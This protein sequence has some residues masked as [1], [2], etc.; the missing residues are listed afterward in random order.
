MTLR[1]IGVVLITC[2][3]SIILAQNSFDIEKVNFEDLTD[4]NIRLYFEQAKRSGYSENQLI[5]IA[6]LKGLNEIQISN[7]KSRIGSLSAQNRDGTPPNSEGRLR[8]VLNSPNIINPDLKT[9]FQDGDGNKSNEIFGLSFFRNSKLTFQ[10]SLNSPTPE[11]YIVG[12]GDEIIIDIWGAAEQ[13]YNLTV[14]PEGSIRIPDIGPVYLNGY[15]VSQVKKRIKSSL[16]KIYSSLDESTYADVS[17]GKIRSVRFHVIGEALNPGTYSISSFGNV[18][19]ALQLAGGPNE[20]GSLRNIQIFRRN[21]LI[22][23]LDIYS[24][25]SNGVLPVTQ[26]Q[27]QDI[28]LIPFYKKRV[29]LTGEVL[30][31]GVF[32]MKDGETIEDLMRFCG[33]PTEEAYLD[34]INVKRVG[35][36]NYELLTIEKDVFDEVYLVNGDRIY[37]KKIVN[38]FSNR[39]VVDGAVTFPGEYALEANMTLGDLIALV[40]GLRKDAYKNRALLLRKNPDQ[41]YVNISIDLE[42][43]VH[44]DYNLMNDDLIII[45]SIFDMSEELNVQIEGE[46][47][48]PGE[49][50]YTDNLTIED[51]LFLAGGFKQSASKSNIEVSRRI[52]SDSTTNKVNSFVFSISDD[53]ILGESASN[54]DLQ[55]LDLV[56]V[57]KSPLFRKQRIVELEGE[58]TYPGK[59]ALLQIDEPLSSVIVRAGGIKSTAYPDGATLLRRTEYY[60]KNDSFLDFKKDQLSTLYEMDSAV[61]NPFPE[62]E[63]V[64]IELANILNGGNIKSDII[65]QNGDIIS[66]PSRLQT[67]RIRGEVL[68]P[69]SVFMND[70]WNFKDY[71]NQTGGFTADAHRKKVY[72]IHPSGKVGATST[73]FWIKNYPE[74]KPGAEI[75]VPRKPL[76]TKVDIREIIAII[77]SLAT[78]ALIVDR[79]SR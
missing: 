67:V 55:P 72:T 6:R 63:E 49:Y 33:G 65:L 64:G 52:L 73:F 70:Q 78:I 24:L 44:L 56:S 27:D 46:V 12:P 79:V 15:K 2:L 48:F 68:Y 57:R 3:S 50:P 51:L 5:E 20:Q 39:V 30:R 38:Q 69:R 14:S 23:S 11:D 75:I 22:D 77:G 43:S 60:N 4:E 58:F 13:I 34:K 42:D 10:P 66:L 36:T 16:K 7:L 59:Y 35:K 37:V 53:L 54:F 61:V 47:L 18:I 45:K 8:E 74:V 26:I 40:A 28:I 1:L 9:N 25:V 76:R 41:T 62:F 29:H 17:L 32:E 21:K 71:V 19:N 31:T